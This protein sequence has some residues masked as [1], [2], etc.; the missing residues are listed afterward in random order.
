MRDAPTAPYPSPWTVLRVHS[1]RP[2]CTR[3][4]WQTSSEGATCAVPLFHQ[5]AFRSYSWV[6]PPS[7]GRLTIGPVA[8][9]GGPV[10]SSGTVEL[11]RL[12]RP[13][14]VVVTHELAQH[15]AQV[16]L[17]HHDDVA[18]AFTPLACGV[19]I[20]VSTVRM[21]MRLARATKCPP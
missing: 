19:A 15:V 2:V 6:S 20:G 7:T 13:R 9:A 5:A 4:W 16:A 18:Q 12:V 10:P 21:P 17:V 8:G 11:Q 14:G 1:A 3:H